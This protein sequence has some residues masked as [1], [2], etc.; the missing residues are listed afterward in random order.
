MIER[1]TYT[2]VQGQTGN[3]VHT[4]SHAGGTNNCAIVMIDVRTTFITVSSVTYGGVAMTELKQVGAGVTDIRYI[5]GLMNPPQGTQDVVTTLSGV[6]SM[7]IGTVTYSGV[8]SLDFPNIE[9]S[10]R[11]TTGEC[12]V[13]VTTTVDNCVLVGLGSYNGLAANEI[14]AGA[15]TTMFSLYNP[16]TGR[17]TAMFESDPF[18]TG[19]AGSKSMQVTVGGLQELVLVVVALAPK[20]SSVNFFPFFKP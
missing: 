11:T 19:T 7:N 15:D 12:T 1:V 9:G 5:F 8:S 13:S 2:A 18:D 17:N 14:A 3:S 6:A 20:I 16:G 4:V 10:N